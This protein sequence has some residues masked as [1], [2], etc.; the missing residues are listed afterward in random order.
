MRPGQVSRETLTA[1]NVDT[2]RPETPGTRPTSCGRG[3]S[4]TPPLPLGSL[5]DGPK[6]S[7][8][9]TRRPGT[10]STPLPRSTRDSHSTLP[11]AH[12]RVLRR[13]EEAPARTSTS[14]G[15]AIRFV[16]RSTARVTDPPAPTRA[17][18]AEDGRGSLF[19]ARAD[20]R[21]HEGTRRC[22]PCHHVADRAYGRLR[23]PARRARRDRCGSNT[24]RPRT[25]R[26]SRRS[27]HPPPP[28]IGPA[29][30]PPNRLG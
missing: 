22:R 10:R 15:D 13:G 9:P 29:G 21:P 16:Q 19:R 7:L 14:F 28:G 23:P 30:L 8:E 2:S 17:P 20:E 25:C 12:T 24:R 4:P 11:S 3:S 26:P 18:L 5:G 6:R 1:A 27:G